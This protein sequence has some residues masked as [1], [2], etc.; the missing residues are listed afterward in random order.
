MSTELLHRIEINP[1][2][3]M[4]KPVIRNTR[5]TVEAILNKLAANTGAEEILKDYPQLKSEDIQACLV[6]AAQSV[7]TEEIYLAS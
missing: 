5:V 7:G 6:Y 3:M 2:V 4:G 1:R